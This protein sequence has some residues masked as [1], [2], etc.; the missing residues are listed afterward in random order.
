MKLFIFPWYVPS[1]FQKC[2]EINRKALGGQY[3]SDNLFEVFQ[4][5]C[6]V[7][8]TVLS[9]ILTLRYYTNVFGGLYHPFYHISIYYIIIHQISEGITNA[10]VIRTYIFKGLTSFFWISNDVRCL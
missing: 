9:F 6:L 10:F 1:H 8:C 3:Q 4:L 7:A 5:L 2:F